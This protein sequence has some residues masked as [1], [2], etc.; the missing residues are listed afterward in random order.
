MLA[1]PVRLQI[2]EGCGV[3]AGCGAFEAVGDRTAFRGL[4]PRRRPARHHGEQ[5]RPGTGLAFQHAYGHLSSG[6][7]EH[8]AAEGVGLSGGCER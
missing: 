6:L 1:L 8:G 5:Q 2:T 4:Y 3:F 7:P